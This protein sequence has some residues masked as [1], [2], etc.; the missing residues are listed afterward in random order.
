VGIIAAI[1]SAVKS[2]KGSV[3]STETGTQQNTSGT[4][5]PKPRGMATGGLVMGIGGPKSDLIPAMLS[6]GESVINAQSTSMFRPL[7]SS[8]NEIG[9]GRRFAEG[10]LSVGSFSQNQALSQLQNSMSFQQTPIKTYVVASDM[11]NQQMMDR[12]IKTRSTL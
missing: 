1:T 10:G 3:G 8:I 2:A 7:L 5:V 4:A 6:N 9:G 11:S 12:N